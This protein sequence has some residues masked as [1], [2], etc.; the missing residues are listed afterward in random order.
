MRVCVGPHINT[1]TIERLKEAHQNMLTRT[2]K[3]RLD[4]SLCDLEA[5]RR[6]VLLLTRVDSPFI[7]KIYGAQV[8]GLELWIVM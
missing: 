4:D 7:V 1:T 3:V 2:V 6:E 5:C 8:T